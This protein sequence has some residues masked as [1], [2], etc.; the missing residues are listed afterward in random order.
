MRTALLGRDTTVFRALFPDLTTTGETMQIFLPSAN[1]VISAKVLDN[2]R[3]NKQVLEL[4]QIYAAIQGASGWS[5]HPAVKMMKN[6]PLFV[7]ALRKLYQQEW[8]ARGGKVSPEN[9]YR[10]EEIN[11][12]LVKVP[13]FI[14]YQAF[15]MS[16]QINLL[17][18]DFSYYGKYFQAPDSAICEYLWPSPEEEGVF[19]VGP[20]SK[21]IRIRIG[22][23][24]PYIKCVQDY[25][26]P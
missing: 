6:Y 8:S 25:Q 21:N 14:G 22:S 16:H 18:K 9:D 20:P 12:T 11:Y 4:S 24:V 13:W 15:H 3:L 19:F 10:S 26:I 7:Q 23:H 2:R 1:P 17:R 5:H